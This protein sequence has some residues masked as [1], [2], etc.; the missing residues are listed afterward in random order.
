MEVVKAGD[1]VFELLDVGIPLAWKLDRDLV[2]DLQRRFGEVGGWA[3]GAG[4]VVVVGDS[5]RAV[6]LED[7]VENQL[8][9]PAVIVEVQ[10]IVLAWYGFDVPEIVGEIK[11][12]MAGLAAG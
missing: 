3:G 1:A 9:S 2:E 12:A 7:V 8:F 10:G 5:R 6:S 11:A 4:L